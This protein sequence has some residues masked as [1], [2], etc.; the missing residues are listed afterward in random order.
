MQLP[1][2]LAPWR[3]WLTLLDAE[4]HAP[5][6]R[7]LLQLQPL[8]GRLR[9]VAPSADELPVGVGDIVRRGPY[10]RMLIS[11]WAYADAAPDEFIRRAASNELL[12]SGPEPEVQRCS[13]LCVALF[14]AGPA[15]LGAPRL[16]HLALF[17][18]LARR[19]E[20]GGAEFR[21][22]T[23]Q[24]PDRLHTDGGAAALTHLLAER[25]LKLAD[26]ADM[27]SWQDCLAALDPAVRDC[28][29]IG[30]PGGL[31]PELANARVGIGQSLLEDG[32]QVTLSQRG[33]TRSVQLELPPDQVGVHLLRHP[34]G[35]PM[36]KNRTRI[37]GARPSLKQAP[38][39]SKDGRW[40]VT[41]MADGGTT[42]FNVPQSLSVTP[43]KPRVHKALEG[44]SLLGATVVGKTSLVR[45]TSHGDTIN[46]LGLP[47]ERFNVQ[48]IARPPMEQFRAPPGLGRLLPTFFLA[49][50]GRLLMIDI[51]RQLVCWDATKSKQASFSRVATGVIGAVQFG[52]NVFYARV[53]QERIE[54]HFISGDSATPTL[55]NSVP[56]T[57]QRVLFGGR[58]WDL[59]D[60]RMVG[61]LAVQTGLGA[62]W[63]R[64][65]GISV[66]IGVPK[67]DIVVGVGLAPM[68]RQ[69]RPGL[70]VLR[71]DHKA[72]YL[73]TDSERTIL[74]ESELEIAQ[75]LLDPSG[76][77]IAWLLHGSCELC[78]RDLHGDELLLRVVPTENVDAS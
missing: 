77:R 31:A 56:V 13:R 70:V 36:A 33:V 1:L 43:G 17:I 54:I 25:S 76:E 28:W 24:K 48:S 9:A 57:G 15:Q 14:D 67:E 38:F 65:G 5:L 47:K 41:A 45:V 71:R 53:A 61:L 7:L 42:L 66:T 58:G 22:G 10:E 52:A 3:A 55:V 63:V 27:D 68:A 8:V 6:G 16:A 50:R 21:W 18:L 32:L 26:G 11:E 40:L 72:V 39:F 44:V 30:A 64:N 49:N 59:L 29:L 62:W 34:L 23:L 37:E 75:V 74:L 2:P 12:F 46:F 4:L 78:V 35:R 73:A 60:K 19:A 20:E 69:S 51:E